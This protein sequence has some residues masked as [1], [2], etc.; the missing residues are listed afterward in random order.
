MHYLRRHRGGVVVVVGVQS[1]GNC[2][3]FVPQFCHTAIRLRCGCDVTLI[4]E[5][6]AKRPH[7]GV[8]H[9][10]ATSRLML[11]SLSSLSTSPS[12]RDAFIIPKKCAQVSEGNEGY[13]TCTPHPPPVGRFPGTPETA[14]TA[15]QTEFREFRFFRGLSICKNKEQCINLVFD[16]NMLICNCLI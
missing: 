16:K 9:L 13:A 7:R 15:S 4:L 5:T 14:R 8:T 11:T 2:L 6:G 12:A 3:H 1:L 10:S